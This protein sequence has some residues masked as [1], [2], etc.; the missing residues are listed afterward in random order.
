MSQVVPSRGEQNFRPRYR[1]DIDGLR[2]LA[3]LAVVAYHAVPSYALGGF[4]GVDIFFVI[5]GYLISLIIFRGLAEGR[6]GFLDFYARRARRILPALLVVA[7]A[8]YAFGWFALLPDEYKQLGKHVAAGMGFA[9]NFVLWNEAGYF[10]VASEFKPLMHLWS[11][12]ASP[13]A[14][15]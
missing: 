15:G 13:C 6:F 12:A 11:L 4:I 3:I 1:P 9:Q 10:D 2:A 5:S 7:A 8:C 14:H